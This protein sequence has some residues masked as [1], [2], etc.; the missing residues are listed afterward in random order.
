[1]SGIKM[2]R[3]A[4]KN[5]KCYKD[6]Q[7][8][9]AELNILAGS[10]A[11]GKSSFIQAI[12]L[13]FQSWEE[14]DK[15]VVNTNCVY[16]VNLG[17]PI[18]I[19][20]ENFEGKGITLEIVCGG[21][22]NRVVLGMDEDGGN[23]MHIRILNG[24]EIAVQ[25]GERNNLKHMHL[26]FLNAERQGPRV[27]SPIRE[28]QP[29]FVGYAGENTGYLISEIDKRQKLQGIKLPDSL[30]ISPLDRFSANCEAWLDMLIPNTELQCSVDMEKNLSTIKFKN[31]G[32]FY[33]PTATGFGITY[34]L[35]IIVQALVAST[36]E[37]SVLI[38]ENPEAHLHPLSQSR[39]GKFLALV[40]WNGVQVLIETHS[41]HVIDGCRIQAAKEKMCGNV[42]ILFFEKNQE[43]SICK[44]IAVQENGELE[45]WPAG[46][47]DQKRQDLRELLEMRRCGN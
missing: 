29:N 19:I 47:F 8:D 14:F 22:G 24:E 39:L 43:N 26:F 13:A 46:F 42:R 3:V 33:L 12:L 7:I 36:L 4:W 10:N 28:I 18:N 32:E 37:N 38:V 25:R 41:E 5:F 44:S 31:S 2:E 45:E 27:V 15:N 17:L 35:P 21:C 6:F 11:A 16:G 20:S 40:A 1:M 34:V 9:L 30:K 23:D